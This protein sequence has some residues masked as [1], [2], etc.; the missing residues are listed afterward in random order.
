MMLGIHMKIQ[1]S[2]PSTGPIFG[3]LGQD[4]CKKKAEQLMS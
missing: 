1:R 3:A 4:T 2:S